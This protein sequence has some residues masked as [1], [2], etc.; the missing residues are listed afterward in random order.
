MRNAGLPISYVNNIYDRTNEDNTRTV[1][2]QNKRIDNTLN[3]R[4]AEVR[5]PTATLC[6]GDFDRPLRIEVFDWDKHGKHVSMGVADTSVRA[7]LTGN[8]AGMHVVEIDKKAKNKSY[9][10]SGSLMA[11]NVS[12]EKNP[13]FTDVSCDF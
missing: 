3:P 12:I 7:M 1:V 4:W 10:N 11:T 9:V 8:G 13:T 2:F 5:I 6:N